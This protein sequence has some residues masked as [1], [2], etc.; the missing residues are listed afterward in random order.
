MDN[1][2]VHGDIELSNHLVVAEGCFG[3]IS[4]NVC[5]ELYASLPRAKRDPLLERTAASVIRPFVEGLTERLLDQSGN[6]GSPMDGLA[7]DWSF[8]TRRTACTFGSVDWQISQGLWDAIP[9]DQREALYGMADSALHDF[10]GERVY[11]PLMIFAHRQ[12]RG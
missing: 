2:S 8:E 6:T 7:Q 9:E 5:S 12:M 1:A 3:T 10:F 11:M 4:W